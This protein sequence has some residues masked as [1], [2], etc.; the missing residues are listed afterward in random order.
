M[1]TSTFYFKSCLFVLQMLFD[2][3]HCNLV[4]LLRV[5]NSSPC[6]K[7]TV[8]LA[9][10][11]LIF[12]HI[13][14]LHW[15]CLP[16]EQVTLTKGFRS[17]VLELQMWLSGAFCMKRVTLR[18]FSW[19]PLSAGINRIVC[20]VWRCILLKCES[21]LLSTFVFGGNSWWIQVYRYVYKASTSSLTVIQSLV[22]WLVGYK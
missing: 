8:L 16:P 13:R 5:L 9:D 6:K 17:R 7:C 18:C 11:H 1:S 12:H 20:G 22:S 3:F 19:D 10:N 15:D 14:W 21:F 2:I 4:P